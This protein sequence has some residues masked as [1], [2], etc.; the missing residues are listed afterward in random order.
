MQP[1]SRDLLHVGHMGRRKGLQFPVLILGVLA[2]RHPSVHP[3]SRGDLFCLS[4]LKVDER[5]AGGRSQGENPHDNQS[6]SKLMGES[7]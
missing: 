3:G 5:C 7:R 6:E 2:F 4:E 1:V